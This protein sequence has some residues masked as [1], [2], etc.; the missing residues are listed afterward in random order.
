MK[1]DFLIIGQGI[2]GTCLAHAL[3]QQGAK[4]I[5]IDLPTEN[6]SS[7]IA[8]GI[9]NP[10]TGKHLSL[11]WEA[12]AIFSILA[13]FYQS[14]ETLLEKQFFYP[15]PFYRRFPNIEAQNQ[16]TARLANES[17]ATFVQDVPKDT[18]NDW[19]DSPLG[20][21]QT[22]FSGYVQVGEL[23]KTFSAY[24]SKNNAFRETRFEYNALQ[25]KQNSIAY[26]DIEAKKII[27]CEGLQARQNPYW[28]DLPFAPNKGEWIKIRLQEP[29]TCPAI[30][31]QGVF[32]LPLG[33]GVYQVG[34]TYQQQFTDT[35][36]SE[37]GKEE[38][39]IQL[40]AWLKVPFEVIEQGAGV[41]PATRSRRPVMGLHET[42]STLGI[43]NGLGS[44]GVSLAPLLATEF[45]KILLLTT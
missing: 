10:I 42:H 35:E 19:I 27:F 6:T 14:M 11:T 38:L 44:K 7:V 39:L 32:F 29:H 30:L 33:K 20:G 5:V 2:A 43:L 4:V 13:P 12:E 37:A 16:H 34:A 26:H 28:A 22:R 21:W 15:M 17:L 40:R 45:A 9:C 41:R 8:A 1:T 25:V 31:K 23:L 36:P 18:Y 24:L 3:L